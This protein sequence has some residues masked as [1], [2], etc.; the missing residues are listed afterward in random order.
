MM[1][2]PRC[3]V[4]LARLLDRH[5]YPGKRRARHQ[6]LICLLP[7]LLLLLLY[8]SETSNISDFQLKPDTSIV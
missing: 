3:D 2:P 5:I 4:L 8:I 7:L 1:M 6:M